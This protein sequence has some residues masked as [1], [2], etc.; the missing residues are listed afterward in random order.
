M[1]TCEP[2]LLKKDFLLLDET[3]HLD[4]L[5]TC[6]NIVPLI[7]K[8]IYL[9]KMKP[10]LMF[11]FFFWKLHR[12]SAQAILFHMDKNIYKTPLVGSQ[13]YKPRYDRY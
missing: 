8:D 13:Y 9:K 12:N 3:F 1:Q 7:F 10:L 4:I 6:L 2:L 5:I 11:I